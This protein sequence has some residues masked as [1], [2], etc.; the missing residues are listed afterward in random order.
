MDPFVLGAAIIGVVAFISG[1]IWLAWQRRRGKPEESEL[2]PTPPVRKSPPARPAPPPARR[3][4]TETLVWSEPPDPSEPPPPP[5]RESSADDLFHPGPMPRRMR[6]LPT[7]EPFDRTFHRDSVLPSLDWYILRHLED[8]E[9]MPARLVFLDADRAHN[10]LLNRYSSHRLSKEEIRFKPPPSTL[11]EMIR[12]EGAAHYIPRYFPDE[13]YDAALAMYKHELIAHRLIDTIAYLHR[14]RD[15]ARPLADFSRLFAGH[16]PFVPDAYIA[17]YNDLVASG[18]DFDR[19]EGLREKMRV[20]AARMLFPARECEMAY[21]KSR[22]FET[23]QIPLPAAREAVTD[24]F[25]LDADD[26]PLAGPPA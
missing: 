19:V 21:W 5:V 12:P 4:E 23:L 14:L 17:F 1:I 20:L 18:E 11:A 26:V 22:G 6:E 8:Q 3:S 7:P 25:L 16:T 13:E 9:R 10:D 2:P 24:W 15:G